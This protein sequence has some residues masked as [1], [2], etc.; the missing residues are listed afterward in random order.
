MIDGGVVTVER[1]MATGAPGVY[2]GGDMVPSDR[3]ATV[4]I[5]HG[6]KAARHIDAYLRGVTLQRQPKHEI[7][8]PDKMNSWYYSDAPDR[9]HPY[10]KRCD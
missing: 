5:G 9:S 10:S 4:A 2:A 1:S 3:N 7:A 6:K 8:T